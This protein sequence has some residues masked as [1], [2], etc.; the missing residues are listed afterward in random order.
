MEKLDEAL[1]IRN[2]LSI[3]FPR[4]E[5]C[6]NSKF[7]MQTRSVAGGASGPGAV[8]LV[9]EYSLGILLNAMQRN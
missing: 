1:I 2:P 5:P 6:W 9:I 3:I 4:G 8:A 7:A